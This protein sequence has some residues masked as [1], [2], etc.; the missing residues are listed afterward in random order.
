[1][2]TKSVAWNDGS[3]DHLLLTYQ[4]HGNGDIVVHTGEN[5]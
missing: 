2:A 1:M 3:G 4:G 5:K